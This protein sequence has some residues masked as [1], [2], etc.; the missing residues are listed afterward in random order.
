M[1]ASTR[2]AL[3]AVALGSVGLILFLTQW[4]RPTPPLDGTL[5]SP[6]SSQAPAPDAAAAQ[7]ASARS[8]QP[9]GADR[10]ALHYVLNFAAPD[11]AGGRTSLSVELTGSLEVAELGQGDGRQ[12]ALRL[13]DAHLNLDEAA[14]KTLSFPSDKAAEELQLPLVVALDG[15]GRSEAVQLAPQTSVATRGLWAAVASAMQFVRPKGAEAAGWQ[16]EER[17]TN[18]VYRANYR[19]VRAGVYSKDATADAADL[20]RGAGHA[21]GYNVASTTTFEFAGSTLR[22]LAFQQKGA[23]GIGQGG[24]DRRATFQVTVRLE[25]NGTADPS[26]V[27]EVD[28]ARMQ[29]FDAQAA[30]ATARLPETR[31]SLAE[32][33]RAAK[34]AVAAHSPHDRALVA[35]ELARKLRLDEKLV[36][37]VAA[38]LRAGVGDEG[39]ERTLVEALVRADSGPAQRALTDLAADPEQPQ[40]R[41]QTV[42]AGAVFVPHPTAE[43]QQALARMAYGKRDPA[44]GSQAALTLGAAVKRAED[45]DAAAAEAARMAAHAKALRDATMQATD[46]QR[47]GS[48]THGVADATITTGAVARWLSALGNTASPAVLPILLD[49]LKDERERVRLAAA[50]ALRWQDPVAVGPAMMAAMRD[51]DSIHVRDN[52]VRA[53]RFLGAEHLRPLVAKALFSD[54]SELVRTAAAHTMTVWAL[55]APGLRDD[56]KQALE[57]E[58]SAKVRE[59][60]LNF[61]EPGRVAPPFKLVAEGEDKP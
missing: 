20:A 45:Q 27:A 4:P 44:F 52:L 8:K 28:L 43:F 29:R 26:W 58:S 32:L 57:R 60:L 15:D 46:P 54:R 53:A 30:A 59:T 10:Y 17:D 42:L 3:A 1:K 11:R 33:M 47:G 5:T 18:G 7:A 48:R 23:V 55:D 37:E 36:G 41:R 13:R 24:G 40:A 6:A 2:N 21:P 38:R 34:V 14:R 12:L 22:T 19:R 56:L 61:L 16:A 31:A 35:N 9:H 50:L 39:V 51:D 25:R 49:A